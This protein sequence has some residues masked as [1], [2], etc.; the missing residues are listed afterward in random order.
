MGPPIVPLTFS[1]NLRKELWIFPSQ[2]ITCDGVVVSWRF[3]ATK[4][5]GVIMAGIWQQES[6]ETFTLIGKTRLDVVA[7]GPHVCLFYIT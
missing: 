2:V 1:M 6:N 7:E 3:Y 5:P 4:A